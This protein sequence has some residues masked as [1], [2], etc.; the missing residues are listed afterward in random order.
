MPDFRRLRANGITLQLRKI[1][2]TRSCNQSLS[3]TNPLRM[4]VN[5]LFGKPACGIPPS[6]M[7]RSGSIRYQESQGSFES[8]ALLAKQR[9]VV[10]FGALV[11][12]H[13]GESDTGYFSRE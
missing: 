1:A 10:A 6:S 2:E 8:N 11:C 3:E 7:S 13:S 5:Y 12:I 4:V 9:Y